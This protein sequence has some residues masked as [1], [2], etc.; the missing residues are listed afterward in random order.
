MTVPGVGPVVALTYR[1]TVDVPS[2]FMA[3]IHSRLCLGKLIQKA[4]SVPGAFLVG[5]AVS[6]GFAA[7]LPHSGSGRV[8]LLFLWRQL[9]ILDLA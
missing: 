9:A 4:T 6:P 3:R 8:F 1:T 2:R 5:F 7:L